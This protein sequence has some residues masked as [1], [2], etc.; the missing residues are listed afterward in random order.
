MTLPCIMTNTAALIIPARGLLDIR[1]ATGVFR[2]RRLLTPAAMVQVT[3][4]SDTCCAEACPR[5][6]GHSR[7]LWSGNNSG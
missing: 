5:P 4:I 2:P 6:S 7:D 1:L 3:A